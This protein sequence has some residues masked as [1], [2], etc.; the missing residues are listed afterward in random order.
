MN[1]DLSILGSKI[2]TDLKVL[3]AKAERLG[4]SAYLV[5]GGVRDLLL[6]Q[7]SFD[8]D[9]V[10]EGDAISLAKALVHGFESRLV[11]YPQFGTATVTFPNGVVLD[12]AS[13]RSEHY[14]HPGVLPV[15]K[16]GSLKED[17]FRRDFTINALAVSLNPDCFGQLRD[18]YGGYGDLK[19]KKVRI[20]HS[21]SF[22]DDPTRILRALRF[23]SRFNFQLEANTLQLLKDAL[24]KNTPAAVKAPRYFAEFRKIFSEKSPV[25]CLKRLAVLHGLDF[26]ALDFHPDWKTLTC[27]EKCI[28]ELKKQKFYSLKDWSGVFLLAFFSSLTSL[29]IKHFAKQ[30]HLTK[31][32]ILSLSSLEEIT[33][34]TDQLKVPYLVA[35]DIYEILDPVDLEIIYFIRARTSVNMVASRID[36]FLKK[37]RLVTLQITGKDLKT[38]G[39]APGRQ[40]GALLHILLLYK[41]DGRIKNHSDELALAK[42]LIFEGKEEFR[43]GSH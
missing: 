4:F 12:L 15:V 34:I 20:L 37:W 26:I 31:E 29:Q 14:S 10:V 8:L 18:F 23:V 43:N 24:A 22:I 1:I 36:H 38:L 32:E 6:K 39:L 19:N 30:F 33:S 7:K 28:S 11:T 41:I 25:K 5:G 2:F 9:I 3:G 21:K 17:L 13:A 40:M 16:K 42:R 35:S 27:V